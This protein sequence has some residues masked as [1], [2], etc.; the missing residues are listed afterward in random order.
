MKR[1]I[2]SLILG[3]F[4][5]SFSSAYVYDDFT[6][7]VVNWSFWQN[8][9]SYSGGNPFSY[10]ESTNQL[11]IT[12]DNNADGTNTIWSERFIPSYFIKWINTTIQWSLGAGVG[13]TST[14]TLQIFNQTV[15]TKSSSSAG[16]TTISLYKNLLT[17]KFEI[18][19]GT[20][21]T[22]NIT[23]AG[24]SVYISTSGSGSS[25][26]TREWYLGIVTYDT[27]GVW[28][29]QTS[30][31][32]N[33]AI[34]S[35]FNFTVNNTAILEQ[36][37][38]N[39]TYYFYN[40]LGNLYNKTTFNITGKS[41]IT[42]K[43]FTFDQL[44]NYNWSVE[45]C[46]TNST[47]SPCYTSGNKSVVVGSFVESYEST[48]LAGQFTN[49]VLNISYPNLDTNLNAI[50]YL[51]NT[52]YPSTR[53]LINSSLIQFTV[54]TQIPTSWGNT[55][56]VSIPHNW[57]YYLDDNSINDTTTTANQTVYTI[58]FDN[59]TSLSNTFINFSIQDEDTLT[60]LNAI[61]ENTS[62]QTYLTLTNTANS[63]SVYSFNSSYNNVN[64]FRICTTSNAFTNSN[65]KVDL[66]VRYTAD[67][68]AIEY[69][70]LQNASLG[71]FPQNITLYPLLTTQAQEFQIEYRDSNFLLVPDVVIQMD[72][73]YLSLG[74][75]L[76]V[77]SPKTD[78]DGKTIG[79]FLLND[80][81]YNIY[82]KKNGI[83]LATFLNQRAFCEP[84]I[85][86]CVIKLNERAG[87]SQVQ[88][89]DLINGVRLTSNYNSTS[90]IYTTIFSVS[91]GSSKNIALNITNF[92]SSVNETLCYTSLNASSGSLSCT[93][94]SAYLNQ[95]AIAYIYI[96]GVQSSS[97]IFYIGDNYNFGNWK[98]FL[99]FGLFLTLVGIGTGNKVV[100][101]FSMV[102]GIILAGALQL[103]DTGGYLSIGSSVIWLV[104]LI[105]LLI[106][107][108]NKGE[109]DAN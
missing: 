9:S 99:A 88:G 42:S 43:Q 107:K 77:E 28:N 16:T 73:Q 63:S 94:P 20:A 41:N 66:E 72:R 62:V 79:N 46:G 40:T 89:A 86:S 61:A 33:L 65:F 84:T 87:T 51:N 92:K 36:N 35:P 48:L 56:G 103:L 71:Q 108:L 76:T 53:S 55:S 38:T 59:C 105:I 17:G 7:G 4:L 104:I 13:G 15:F 39:I 1:I 95:S 97:S 14:G 58:G 75:F 25:P 100:I 83:T 2:L 45:T 52:L 32:D 98:Y 29:N 22:T 47:Y 30:P 34:N 21:W 37:L 106:S 44:G 49:Y 64:P 70:N 69:Y 50:L 67:N 82:V 54:S 96:D 5:I 74:G 109:S 6:D 85:Q 60:S 80:V 81:L 19:N 12:A 68:Y 90:R 91:D 18:N 11:K 26:Y 31:I 93:I 24:N 23:P 57:R 27:Y 101:G 78:S 102:M 3:I 10:T 8:S